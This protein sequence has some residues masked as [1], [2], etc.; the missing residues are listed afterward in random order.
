M[1]YD[2]AE[3]YHEAEYGD[4]GRESYHDFC[5]EWEAYSLMNNITLLDWQGAP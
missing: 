3:G 4:V 5:W 1:E 2:V